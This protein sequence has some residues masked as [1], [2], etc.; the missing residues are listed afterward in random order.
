MSSKL[1]Q[2]SPLKRSVSCQTKCCSGPH[3]SL[4]RHNG[5]KRHRSESLE[6]GRG[7]ENVKIDTISSMSATIETLKHQVSYLQQLLRDACT[8]LHMASIP[9]TCPAISCRKSFKR[10]GIF[11]N[12]MTLRMSHL[13]AF[14]NETRCLVCSKNLKRS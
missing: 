7:D 4:N 6:H 11:V 1:G 3:E 5:R 13:Q 9:H 10:L 12:R 2:V 8:S 14:I